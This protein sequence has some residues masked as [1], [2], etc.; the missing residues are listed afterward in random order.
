MVMRRPDPS[1]A[2]ESA[3]GLSR[4]EVLLTATAAG[5]LA[6]VSSVR[7]DAVPA[8]FGAPLVE[9]HVP[10]GVL[11]AEQK[12]AMIRG[13][14]DVILR[15]MKQPTDPTRRLFVQIFETAEGGFGVNGQVFVPRGK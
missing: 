14:T 9:V 4:R 6:G 3:D 12:T 8:A 7:A 2:L 1:K 13:V 11:T 15:A 10:A 5:A